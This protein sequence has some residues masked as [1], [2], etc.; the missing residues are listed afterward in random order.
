MELTAH[1]TLALREAIGRSP[2]VARTPLRLKRVSDTF[3]IS[4]TSGRRLG[5]SVRPVHLSTQAADLKDSPVAKAIDDRHA[6]LEADL[7]LGDDTALWNHLSALD[8]ASRLAL[9]ALCRSFGINALQVRVNPYAR[10][11]RPAV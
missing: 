10:A 9:L 7:P 1:R 8:Q 4:S 2:D 5:A 11:S 3:R 6:A